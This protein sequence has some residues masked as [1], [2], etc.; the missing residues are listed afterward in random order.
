MNRDDAL[1]FYGPVRAGIQRVLKAAVRACSHADW[2][3]AAKHLGVWSGDRI[4]VDDEIAI[5]MVADLA[6]FEPNQRKR[7]AYDRFLSGQ[8]RQLDPADLGLANRMAGA[9]FSMFRVAVRHPAAGIWAEDVL[10]ENRR[11]WVLDEGLESSAPVG[12]V[13]GMRLFDMG[14]FHAGFGIVVPADEEIAYFCA[15]ARACGGP[16]PVRHSLA[17]TLYSDEI[18]AGARLGEAEEEIRGSFLDVL[19]GCDKA[20]RPRARAKRRFRS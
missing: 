1:S 12:S 9:F 11:I 20:P 6:L 14:P 13:L 10:D 5:D 7:R 4:V 8:A 2:M 16:L 3:R 19:A 17:A 15:Q 18:R